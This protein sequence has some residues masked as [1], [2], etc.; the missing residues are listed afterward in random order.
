MDNKLTIEIHSFSYKKGGIPKDNSGNGGG[1]V[2]DCRGILNPGR[3]EE[4]K[5]QTGNDISVQEYLE[6][7]TK[8]QDFLNSVFSIVSINIDDYLARGFE[9]LQINF[10][11][12]GGQHR[13]VYSAIKTAAFIREKYP[14]ANVI[15][16]HDEQPQLN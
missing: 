15:L 7:K 3:I 11:C 9:N 10:G 16:H 12:T 2:F 1:F 14:Q 4:Y 13:S 8:I 5:Q 6:E